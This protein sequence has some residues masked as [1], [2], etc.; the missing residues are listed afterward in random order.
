MAQYTH[1]DPRITST[2]AR[3]PPRCGRHFA[4]A[5]KSNM[6]SLSQLTQPLVAGLGPLLPK[7]LGALAILVGAWLVAK[8]V[9]LVLTRVAASAQLDARASSPGL[10]QT[11]AGVGAALVWLMALPSLLGLLEMQSLLG[12][13]TA[14]I[15]KLLGF[16]PNLFG[17]FVVFAV[18]MLVARIASQLVAGALRAAGS[19]N[20]AQKMGLA[21]SLGEGGLAGVVGKVLFVLI[22]LPTVIAAL[23]P[24]GMDTLTQPLARLLDSILNFVPRLI[25]AAVVVA[26]AVFAGRA[27]ATVVA[28]LAKSSG[29]DAWPQKL[30]VQAVQVGG[31]AP[32]DLLGAGVLV[33]II[34]VALVQATELLGLPILTNMVSNAGAALG[35]LVAAGL[36][37]IGG[38]VLSALAG[39][40]L[41][42]SGMPNAKGLAFVARAAI[43]AF[44][45]ALALRQAGLPAEIVAIAFGAAVGAIAIAL[46]VAFGVGGRHVAA[47]AAER[48]AA[49]FDGAGTSAAPAETAE[50]ALDAA[51]P[52]AVPAPPPK[53][54]AP[55]TR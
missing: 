28:A 44:A 48:W 9:R 14:L 39:R 31:R 3:A 49:S 10:G 38:L 30:G 33:A 11:L 36:V 6:D 23:T 50:K 8:L 41:L 12:S 13:V 32:S 7:A 52:H 5:R 24:L 53:T 47:Q 26:I 25:S 42:G 27:M 46:A 40:S 55:E 15:N 54:E 45:G 37:F 51:S 20:A 22:L 43:L 19:E 1:T 21:T 17:A 18:G 16:L 35:D 2:L 29:L 4:E 34:F